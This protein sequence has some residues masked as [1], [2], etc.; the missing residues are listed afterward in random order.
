MEHSE[1]PFE[2]SRTGVV[3]GENSYQLINIF[4]SEHEFVASLGKSTDQ[5]EA[6]TAFI[7]TA[8]NNFEKMVELLKEFTSGWY[9][10]DDCEVKR[11]TAACSGCYHRKALQLLSEIE[12]IPSPVCPYQPTV[13]D[14]C[15]GVEVVNQNYVIWMEGYNAK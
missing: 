7:V 5:S 3:D 8:C 14:E 11:H 1:L 12:G 10:C 15:S 4:T 2:I 6:N 13:I 9:I